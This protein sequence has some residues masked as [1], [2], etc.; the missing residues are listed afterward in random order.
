MK[1]Y[2]DTE[3]HEHKK[4]PK[5]LGIKVGN[6]IDTIELISIGI[7]SGDIKKTFEPP[8]VHHE[9]VYTQREY[10]AICKEFDVEAAWNKNQGTKEK[11]DYWLRENVLK[12]IFDELLEKE[13]AYIYKA[14]QCNVYLSCEIK[15]RFCLRLFKKYLNK[16]GKTRA[17]IT[18][19]IKGF[20]NVDGEGLCNC[21]CGYPCIKGKRGSAPRCIA[22][23]LNIEFYSYYADYHWVVFCWLFGSMMDLPKG[24]PM[25][26]NDLKQIA[27]ETWERTGKNTRYKKNENGH[28][29]LYDAQWDKKFH[30]FL[31]SL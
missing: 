25:Y 28:N 18:E 26:C 9:T 6:P 19:E 1:Y 29:A 30:Q 17:Q 14:Q 22:S 24:F 3:F 31:N 10:Y 13:R 12:G 20:T 7:V 11:P 5:V 15:D 23:E 27:D 8:Y 21:S 4:Q 2:L 16:Y